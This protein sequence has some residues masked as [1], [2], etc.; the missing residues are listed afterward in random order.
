MDGSA[1]SNALHS[2]KY[3]NLD[4]NYTFLSKAGT[5]WCPA[6]LWPR[7]LPRYYPSRDSLDYNNQ[8]VEDNFVSVYIMRVTIRAAPPEVICMMRSRSGRR[9]TRN[10]WSPEP[11]LVHNPCTNGPQ[12]LLR[13]SPT[14]HHPGHI[15]YFYLVFRVSNTSLHLLY[16][17]YIFY[18]YLFSVSFFFCFLYNYFF[19]PWV[20]T[21]VNLESTT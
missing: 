7:H 18:L 3:A 17:L 21:A 2:W 15:G 8:N 20:T 19:Q 14:R 6:L 4:G 11:S 13:M 1:I 9:P 16:L 5:N 10:L 12:L